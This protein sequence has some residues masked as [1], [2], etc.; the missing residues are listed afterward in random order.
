ME[1]YTFPLI[2]R[3]KLNVLSAAGFNLDSLHGLFEY[4]PK[5]AP[6]EGSLVDC[7]VIYASFNEDE[8]IVTKTKRF[9]DRKTTTIFQ[10]V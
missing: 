8:V 5:A 9:L 7:N 4:S 3:Q 10:V 2:N 6:A 1:K